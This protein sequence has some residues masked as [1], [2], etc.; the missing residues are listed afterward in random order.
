MWSIRLWWYAR[1]IHEQQ[2]L[3]GHYVPRTHRFQR[4]GCH[5]VWSNC[6]KVRFLFFLIHNLFKITK[7]SHLNSYS[8][9]AVPVYWWLVSLRLD[10]GELLLLIAIGAAMNRSVVVVSY[11]WPRSK[12]ILS[13]F[14]RSLNILICL[15]STFGSLDEFCCCNCNV[16]SSVN[17]D[18]RLP[19]ALFSWQTTQFTINMTDITKPAKCVYEVLFIFI[20]I[21]I[22]QVK[23]NIKWLYY[24]FS[25]K[26]SAN[27]RS[28]Q[29]FRK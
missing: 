18:V 24:R 5:C 7:H 11:S 17:R 21:E 9:F 13:L 25:K 20:W 2:T 6:G 14:N 29:F 3:S 15:W 1:R 28:C 19:F 16:P 23:M 4:D 27:R 8:P 26:N 22:K 10:F 12:T